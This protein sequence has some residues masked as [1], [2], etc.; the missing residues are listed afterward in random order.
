MSSCS[1][2][3]I[4][5]HWLCKD[6]LYNAERIGRW[7]LA[8]FFARSEHIRGGVLILSKADLK[9]TAL[10][11]INEL[12][13]ELHCE[14]AALRCQTYNVVTICVY[15]SPSGDLDL[16]FSIVSDALNR[17]SDYKQIIICGDFN[18]KFG[19]SDDPAVKL[20]D[21]FSSH[22]FIR[23]ISGATRLDNCLDNIFVNFSVNMFETE[24]HDTCMSD[25]LAQTVALPVHPVDRVSYTRIVTRPITSVGNINFFNSFSSCDWGF[26][27]DCSLNA[28]E[29]FSLFHGNFLEYFTTCYPERQCTVRTKDNKVV[30]FNNS[31]RQMRQGLELVSE[32]YKLQGTDELLTIKKELRSDYRRAITFAKKQSADQYIKRSNNKSKASWEMINANISRQRKPSID[33]DP[34][35][36]NKYFVE[37]PLSIVK[38]LPPPVDT[39]LNL[40]FVTPTNE[41]K[42]SL[43][44]VSNLE[45]RQLIKG[46]KNSHTR[47]V[48]GISTNFI[49]SCVSLYVSPLTKLVNSAF[50][51]SQFPESL[52]QALVVPL[53]KGGNS[54]DV[55]NYRPISILPTLSKVYERALYNRIYNY[56]EENNFLYKNQ[57]GFRKGMGSRDAVVGFVNGCLS[58]FESGEHCVVIFLDLS[59]AFD[60][61]SHSILLRKLEC[62]YGFDHC[63]LSLIKSFLSDRFQR[64]NCN[65][66]ISDNLQ[67]ERG[68]PQGSILGPLLFL[69]F[70]NDF[71][72]YIGDDAD[73]YLYADDATLMVRGKNIDDVV[74]LSRS[75]LEKVRRWTVANELSL[76]EV[77]TVKTTFSLRNINI[78]DDCNS[79]RFLGVYVTPPN[80]KFDDHAVIVGGKISRNIFALR[81]LM[82][83]VSLDVVKMAYYALV[84][85]LATYCILAWGNTPSSAHIFK[86]QRRAVRV[87]GGAGFQGRLQIFI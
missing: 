55:G 73:C 75:V 59:R 57:F 27:N 6:E 40:C 70:F 12:S 39:P 83:T 26:L 38:S 46:L 78:Q 30:W 22:G 4:S 82:G 63:S 13:V 50:D 49:K 47:D 87:L 77:K 21:L 80:L 81:R 3:C 51:S 10:N 19:T 9:C 1:F 28:E 8:T 67:V 58:V 62:V 45:M 54:N 5:E 84:H 29:K 20:C 24:L 42:F 18:V 71:P 48:Y 17:L 56:V 68:V 86:L 25:H 34:N 2:I 14:L 41:T 52:K 61:V 31:L 36:L 74:D 64:V 37:L 35:V 79:T 15:R 53:F 69:L 76:N 43:T 85:S 32:L 33:F 11:C 44:D 65:G 16:F 23:T 72:L 60:C 7:S 66:K